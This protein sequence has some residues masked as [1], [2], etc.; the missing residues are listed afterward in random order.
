MP[1]Q[2]KKWWTILLEIVNKLLSLFGKG[3][4]SSEIPQK[5]L[6]RLSVEANNAKETLKD[7]A[8]DA[9][10]GHAIGL[11]S[12]FSSMLNTL[13]PEQKEFALRIAILKSSDPSEMTMEELLELGDISVEASRLGIDVAK[14]LDSFW[15]KFT[16]IVSSVV[17]QVGGVGSRLVASSL[18]GFLL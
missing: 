8:V 14:T 13:E 2:E 11:I 4:K 10:A 7:I 12:D 15:S 6:E 9:I 5:P 18:T 16:A 17:K 1:Q 3:T